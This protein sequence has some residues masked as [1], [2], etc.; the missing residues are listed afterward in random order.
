MCSVPERSEGSAGK[1]HHWRL[2]RGGGQARHVSG[3]VDDDVG[4]GDNVVMMMVMM[5]KMTTTTTNF[6]YLLKLLNILGVQAGYDARARI[7]LVPS[8][9]V[10][11]ELV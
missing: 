2:L 8:G 1:D 6:N 9:L 7:C 10:Q 4:S 11:G 5:M 3:Q